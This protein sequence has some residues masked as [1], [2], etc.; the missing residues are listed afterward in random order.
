MELLAGEPHTRL[1]YFCSPQHTNSALHPIIGQMERAAGLMHDDTAAN[2]TRQTRCAPST[3][4][5]IRAGRRALC[6]DAVAAERWALSRARAEPAAAPGK[7]AGRAHRA[8]GSPGPR[9]HPVLMVFEDAHW[10]D[11]TSLEL[12]GR[13]VDRIRSLSV[14]L[15]VTFR[16]EF[17]PPWI[18][19]PHVTALTLSPSGAP[20]SRRPDRPH[21]R[22]QAAAG[23]HP[24][25]YHRAHRW[26][27]PVRGR[28]DEGGA[29]GRMRRRST[30]HR[31]L[32]SLPGIGGP[33]KLARIVDG[34][35][36][37]ARPRQGA[38]A[39]R[40]GDR[41][42]ILPCPAGCGRA[43]S[44]RQSSKRQLDSII[45]AGLL[46]RQGV[47]PNATYLFKHALVQDA[48]Y[49]LLLREPRRELH[50]RIAE[51][52]ESRFS[53]MAENKPELL[54][55]HYTEAGQVEK[56]AALWGKAGQRSAG[57]ARRWL[58]P[59]NSSGARS[60]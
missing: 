40:G 47:P 34:A 50:A 2:E 41:T 1:R 21:R 55:R 28:D 8:S 56:A 43:A 17:E 11:P 48:A 10:T 54:A 25:G 23:E 12:F 19:Q 15:I 16:P 31:R 53:E 3:V 52:L 18:G 7:N 46:F 49:G 9:Q 14:L 20:R 39:D 42:R 45:R 51:T 33:R 32:G 60:T 59:Q 30:A 36:R 57:S 29:G 22:Q 38:G 24:A 37:P 44:R 58:K 4:L 5:D 35:A 6:R 26:H 13:T 27:P